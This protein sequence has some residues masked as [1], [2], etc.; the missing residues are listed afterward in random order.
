MFESRGTQSLTREITASICF[1]LIALSLML[2]LT[3]VAHAQSN[4]KSVDIDSPGLQIETAAGLGGVVNLETPLPLS[5]LIHNDS[6][7]N[8]EGSM[9][10]FVPSTGA[11]ISLGNVTVG[12]RSVKRFAVIQAMPD[13]ADCHVLLIQ[14]GKILWRREFDIHSGKAFNRNVNYALF[15]DNGGRNLNLEGSQSD[16]VA[17]VEHEPQIAGKNGRAI[18]CV[19]AKP[20][21]IPTHPGP[22]IIA[23]TMVF[24]DGATER[25]LNQA[26]W[27]AIAQWICQGGDVF[28]HKSSRDIIERLL[29][30]APLSPDAP[31]QSGL[32]LSRRLGLGSIHEYELPLMSSGENPVRKAISEFIAFQGRSPL[33]SFPDAQYFF[34]IERGQ[35]A[36]KNRLLVFGLFGIYTLVSG[37]GSLILFRLNQK[38]IATYSIIIVT[39]AS[40]CAAFLGG[41]LR[42]SKGDA[43]W[44]SVTCAGAGGLVQAAAIDLQSAGSRNTRVGVEGGDADLQIVSN[45]RHYYYWAD[46]QQIGYSPFTWQPNLIAGDK[47]KYQIQVSISPWGQRR[48]HA[49][50][51]RNVVSRVEVDLELVPQ[52]AADDQPPK[53]SKE[54]QEKLKLKVENRLPFNLTDCWLVIGISRVPTPEEKAGLQ[55]W[56]QRY[57]WR[58]RRTEIVDEMIDAYHLQ[59]L[60]DLPPGTTSTSEFIAKFSSSDERT[61]SGLWWQ[62]GFEFPPKIS[63]MGQSKA[64]IVGRISKSPVL[65][66]DEEQSDFIPVDG[67]HF[68]IQELLDDELPEGL[69]KVFPTGNSKE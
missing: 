4:S 27:K 14:G 39:A 25:D 69:R 35:Q 59:R 38:Q 55:N 51:Y 11:R 40:I 60:A 20:W 67:V 19:T 56:N 52:P 43:T 6:E 66:I 47:D 58:Q 1:R 32:F 28:V 22:L 49:T 17:A 15:V 7:R 3:N 23:Q 42:F 53:S 62:Y 10:L 13:W 36:D 31:D 8:I 37:I 45:S 2:V 64:W 5:F 63:H 33:Y 24:P 46:S 26:Q 18:R 65:K 54:P 61:E 16:T 68:Y 12:P 44:M 29:E 57:Y 21:Q 41:Y 34:S 30:L 9:L 50:A 48:C